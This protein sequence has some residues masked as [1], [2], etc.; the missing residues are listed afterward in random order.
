MPSSVERTNLLQT[1]PSIIPRRVA[2]HVEF[3]LR[4]I[5]IA[6]VRQPTIL[7]SVQSLAGPLL[8]VCFHVVGWRDTQCEA[9]RLKGLRVV[10][11]EQ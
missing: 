9:R 6:E 1:N 5:L 4:L 11:V 2:L 8:L 3:V 7:V 10:C